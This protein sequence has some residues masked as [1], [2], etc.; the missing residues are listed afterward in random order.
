MAMAYRETAIA[1]ALRD[2][3]QRSTLGASSRPD[4]RGPGPD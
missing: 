2:E 4:L 3:R 1:Q